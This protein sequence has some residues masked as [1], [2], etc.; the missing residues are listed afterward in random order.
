MTALLEVKNLTKIFS[1]GPGAD[2]VAV[3]DASFTLRRGE[4]LGLVG[5]S[6]SGKTT[7]GRCV[8]RLINPSHGRILLDGMDITELHGD[9]LRALRARMQL[10]FQD[11][12][13]SLNPRFTI[14][15]IVAEPLALHGFDRAER[16]NRAAEF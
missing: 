6:G 10:V 13:A 15:Q 3:R 4:T 12:F 11:P 2:L 9:R 8:L 16:R 1:V 14:Q 7:V 5:E